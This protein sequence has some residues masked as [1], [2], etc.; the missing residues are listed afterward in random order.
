MYLRVTSSLKIQY[1]IL[2]MFTKLIWLEKGWWCLENSKSVVK[3]KIHQLALLTISSSNNVADIKINFFFDI[4]IHIIRTYLFLLFSHYFLIYCVKN[5]NIEKLF[6]HSVVS[7]VYYVYVYVFFLRKVEG[8][9]FS[10]MFT[11]KTLKIK[12]SCLLFLNTH[13]SNFKN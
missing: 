2:E 6:F 10:K 9:L 1:N 13:P 11:K 4:F 12:F 8:F 3:R 5:F 7:K